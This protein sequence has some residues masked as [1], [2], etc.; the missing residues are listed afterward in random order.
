MLHREA[1]QR[2]SI[3]KEKEIFE[4]SSE[5]ITVPVHCACFVEESKKN[6]Q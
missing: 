2:V 3:E 1:Y 4:K 6:D 5:I